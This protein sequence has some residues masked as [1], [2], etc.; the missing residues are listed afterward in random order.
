MALDNE[1]PILEVPSRSNSLSSGDQRTGAPNLK[2]I[3]IDIRSPSKDDLSDTA[4][5]AER[6]SEE[7]GRGGKE[8]E[9]SQRAMKSVSAEIPHSVVEV[10]TKTNEDSTNTEEERR[11]DGTRSGSPRN[12]EDMINSSE[13]RL[14]IGRRQGELGART[15]SPLSKQNSSGSQSESSSPSLPPSP[16]PAGSKTP[17]EQPQPSTATAKSRW[18]LLRSDIAARH[19]Q[20]EILKRS[21]NDGEDGGAAKSGTMLSPRAEE[22][23]L[24]AEVKR[25]REA[26]RISN[27]KLYEFE[28]TQLDIVLP[29]LEAEVEKLKQVGGMIGENSV[30]L[31][32][33]SFLLIDDIC[34]L[35][36]KTGSSEGCFRLKAMSCRSCQRR[37]SSWMTRI[38]IS[39]LLR[40][41]RL[42]SPSCASRR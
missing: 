40:A 21:Q 17:E 36:S 22:R 19:E 37:G 23:D 26:L 20:K 28:R 4:E 34:F 35:G 7:R 29:K 32:N 1:F 39:F 30:S 33:L 41:L 3:A 15:P 10:S 24:E 16:S 14:G 42:H 27:K 8:K 2:D 6:V 31:C 18:K 25:L 5:S 13:G 11:R 38:R 12:Q 9:D